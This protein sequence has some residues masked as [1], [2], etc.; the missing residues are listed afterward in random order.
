MPE[1][2]AQNSPRLPDYSSFEL[3]PGVHL[4]SPSYWPFTLAWG[5]GFLFMGF[6]LSPAFGVVG[7]IVIAVAL[8][9]WI[10]ELLHG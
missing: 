5:I 6:V 1:P 3:P 9:G 4:P 8:R 7:V 2:P 10:G